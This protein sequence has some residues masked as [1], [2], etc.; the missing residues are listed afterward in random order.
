MHF[1]EEMGGVT[2]PTAE[3]ATAPPAAKGEGAEASA[4]SPITVTDSWRSHYRPV[5]TPIPPNWTAVFIDG[6]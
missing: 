4:Q 3:K 5:H 2:L 1:A 6:N